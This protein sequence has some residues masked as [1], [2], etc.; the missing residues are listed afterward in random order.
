M[1]GEAD[2]WRPTLGAVV[3]GD[4]VRF[5]IWA[6][7]PR[8]LRLLVQGEDGERTLPMRR[9]DDMWSCEVSGLAP[10]TR[11]AYLA[12]GQGPF[13]DP[14]TRW[15]PDG[16]HGWSAVVD[17]RRFAWA[18]GA[19]SPPPFD[20]VAIYETHIGTLTPEGTF[21]AALGQLPRLRQL[22]ITAIEV[23]PVAAF[24]GRWNWGYDGVALFAPCQAY[25]GPDAFR[26]FIDAAHR[27]GLA[28]I[29]DV[30]YNHFGPDGNYT[31]VYSNEYV[32]EAHQTPW[33]AAINFDGP[34]SR[35]VREFYFENL[36]HWVTEYHVDGF[37]FD[38][39]H[40]IIDGSDE[41]ILAELSR[42]IEEVTQGRP[43]PYLIAESHEND[44]RYLLPRD[45]GG[46]GFDA[47]WADDFHHAV[48]TMLTGES[49]GYLRGF[50]GDP[51]TVA[52]AV[53]Q[54]FVYEGQFDA[55]FGGTRGTRAREQPWSQF[56]YCIQNHDQV[57][58][59]AYGQR[60]HHTIGHDTVFAATL[61]LLL[62]PQ[63]PLLFQGQE[64]LAHSPF[65]YFTDHEPELGRLVTEGRRREF[66][67]FGAFQDE[68]IRRHIPDPQDPATFVRSKLDLD[69]GAY[70]MGELAA[71]FHRVLLELRRADGVLAAFRRE[72]L[73]IESETFGN[74]MSLRLR[75]VAGSRTIVANF[76]D[77]AEVPI[78]QSG[79]LVLHSS[80][81]RF[82]GTG[83]A[84]ELS[85]GR[86]LLPPRTAAFIAHDADGQ[87]LA[88][89][90]ASDRASSG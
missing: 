80:E 40:A 33:G 55:G 58:N 82:G 1:T 13:P 32:T 71:E 43:R 54:G 89:N 49:E 39:T 25:G 63:T 60:L 26:R 6:P 88:T 24:P 59:R 16:V 27:S 20:E 69:T 17:P 10:G 5:T 64:F 67:G 22:G 37:R 52:T 21:D 85:G 78:Q 19:W 65:M 7:R 79:R 8:E 29:L 57:G 15:Q 51:A 90:T 76:G 73:P 2:D 68:S 84:P 87:S 66:S 14:C 45:K 83:R 18:D 53:T 74:V 31:G 36:T 44:V 30:V 28:I 75:S 42:R 70:G 86:I 35:Q 56:V 11:Y 46:F 72:R 62:V 77:E 12:D 41:H 38:A 34:G 48:R 9:E 3:E 61:I 4:V 23:M 50:E 81:A 47:V